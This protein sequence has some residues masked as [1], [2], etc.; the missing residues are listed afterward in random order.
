MNGIAGCDNYLAA[1]FYECEKNETNVVLI[2][3][4]SVI[5]VVLGLGGIILCF[6]THKSRSG[7]L[8]ELQQMADRRNS[9]VHDATTLPNP[10]ELGGTYTENGQTQQC[11]YV[12]HMGDNGFHGDGHDD[13][14]RATVEGKIH[15]R[16]VAWLESG[17]GRSME[18][19]GELWESNGQ[20]RITASYLSSYQ[21]TRGTISVQSQPGLGVVVG[22]PVAQGTLIK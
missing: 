4:L 10:L 7:N 12:W 3:I 18:V 16:Q 5:F 17:S 19:F 9:L 22:N 1:V 20:V 13:D 14:G 6:C 2:V 8:K 15:T 11:R 21:N